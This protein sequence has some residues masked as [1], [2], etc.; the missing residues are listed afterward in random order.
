MIDMCTFVAGPTAGRMLAELG[1]EVIR[2]DPL[3]G[4]IDADR[5]PV[6]ESDTSL[7]WA[8][9][10][11]AKKSVA[12][13]LRSDAG[14]E[15]VADLVTEAGVL[16][17]N[18]AHA[19]WLANDVLTERRADLVH[20]HIQGNPDGTPAID[21][22]VNACVG[23]PLMTGPV[24]S[25]TPVNHV[26]PAWDMIS[27]V[28]AALG[29][30][31]A[32]R[33]RDTTGVGSYMELALSDVALSAVAGMGWVAE[34]EQNGHGRPRQGNALY[35]SYGSDFAT[36]DGR[37]VMVVGLTVGQWRALVDATE[38]SDI[39]TAL[40]KQRGL[41]LTVSADRYRARDAITAIIRPWFESRTLA[42][43]EHGLQDSRVLWSV[44]RDL[45]EVASQASPVL[46][47]VD[48]PGANSMLTSRSALRWHGEYTDA[49]SAPRHGEHTADV[50]GAI[51]GLDAERI[52]TLVRDGIVGGVS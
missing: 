45:A 18:L 20:L 27:G 41:D 28:H 33:L 6:N 37:S 8:G 16:V 12:V 1:A 7:Y 22:T 25:T 32:L 23:L 39:F 26:L 48:H 17:E 50:L 35:G 13:D 24:D 10:N 5:W 36:A 51:L 14:R 40:E 30:V 2:I 19:P 49:A 4:A 21:Y 42:E 47:R 11:Q 3:R 52:E 44:Y 31:S 38:T 29:I 34:A 15:L 43:I 46:Q 9:L